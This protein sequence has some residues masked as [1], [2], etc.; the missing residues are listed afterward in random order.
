MGL[1]ADPLLPTAATYPPQAMNTVG[2]R[3]VDVLIAEADGSL[4]ALREGSL[5]Y[6]Q[7]A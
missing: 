6:T 7:D 2:P 5:E 4:G 3:W 1:A